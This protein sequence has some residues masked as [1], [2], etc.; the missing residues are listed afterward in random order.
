MKTMYKAY[1]YLNNGYNSIRQDL[2][3]G[4]V[5]TL[6]EAKKATLEVKHG[7][8]ESGDWGIEATTMD[9]ETFTVKTEVIL[10]FNWWDEVGTWLEAERMAEVYK[11][12][13]EKAEAM[14]PKTEKGE[15]TK[16]TKINNA[17]A[18]IKE[19]EDYLA[20]WPAL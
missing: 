15:Q 3:D 6:E 11:K 18:K 8:F 19:Y 5:A 2:T 20:Q 17:K 4:Y 7:C 13:L 14:K 1:T 9:E 12:E 16:Q 10:F